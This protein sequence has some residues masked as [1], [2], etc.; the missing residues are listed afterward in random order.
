MKVVSEVMSPQV[1]EIEPSSTIS[2]AASL[3]STRRVGS[4]L[5]LEGGALAGIFT[6]RD[7]VRAVSHAADSLQ[8]L[9][10]HWMTRR[11]VSVGPD[12]PVDEAL[13][14]MLKGGFRHL[15]VEAGG[16]VLGVLSIR[17]LASQPP[18]KRERD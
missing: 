3:M 2:E 10:G 7:I 1:V 12:T 18:P 14:V 16:K 5:V 9:V 4:L 11:P 17:D 6:E 13:E 15:P 8:D